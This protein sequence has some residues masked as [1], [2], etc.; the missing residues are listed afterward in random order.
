MHIAIAAVA[1]H[2][3]CDLASIA[4]DLIAGE[5][6]PQ[7]IDYLDAVL[8][9]LDMKRADIPS[10]AKRYWLNLLFRGGVWTM[11]PNSGWWHKMISPMLALRGVQ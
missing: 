5:G 1:D 8:P 10:L 4:C 9:M 6:S 3:R 11:P 7:I 2:Q